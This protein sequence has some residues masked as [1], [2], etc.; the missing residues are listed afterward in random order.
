MAISAEQ[1]NVILSARDREFTRAMERSQR[2][3]ERFSRESNKSLNST[4]RAFGMLINAAKGFLPALSAGAIVAQMRRIVSEGS[5]IATLSQIAGT[6]AE[7]FQRFAVGAQTVGFDMDKT[8]DI[9]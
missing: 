7:E 8:A 4:S 9:I 1:L 3:V 2:R 6:T 5:R